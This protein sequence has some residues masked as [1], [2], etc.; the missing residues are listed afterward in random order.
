[1]GRG[2]VVSGCVA[3]R[4]DAGIVQGRSVPGA[5]YGYCP[6]LKKADLLQGILTAGAG[7]IAVQQLYR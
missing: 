1:M 6:A 3:T 2:V 7:A 4:R 5:K